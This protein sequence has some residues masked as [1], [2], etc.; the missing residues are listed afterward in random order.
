MA[1]NAFGHFK[2]VLNDA[3]HQLRTLLG[4]EVTELPQKEKGTII[5]QMQG[6]YSISMII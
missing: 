6:F 3:H 4:M 1:P 2:L 5:S